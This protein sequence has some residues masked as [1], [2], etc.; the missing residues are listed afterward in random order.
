MN[1]RCSGCAALTGTPGF[2]WVAGVAPAADAYL[3]DGHRSHITL[4]F[5]QYAIRNNIDLL[6]FP[7][8]TTHPLQPLNVGLVGPL[9]K[10]YGKLAD[11]HMPETRAAVVKGTFWKVYS[12]V[13]RQAYT[14]ENMKSAWRKTGIHPFNPNAVL[15]QIT[16]PR[17][18]SYPAS[19]KFVLQTPK[20]STDV[21]QL[22]LIVD[23][24]LKK[25]VVQPK[26]RDMAKKFAHTAS[27]LLHA[28]EITHRNGGCPAAVQRQ[29]SGN[30]RSTDYFTG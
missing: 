3:L 14:K 13:R 4:E 8:H 2:A 10:Y 23:A 20:K 12:A 19:K 18:A 26:G 22:S 1:L 17:S 7:A 5:C 15:T 27:T 11:D 24:E 21:R 6:C 25:A 30:D 28:A 9:Q 29:E 16:T